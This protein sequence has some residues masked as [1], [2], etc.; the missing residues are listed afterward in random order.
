MGLQ[1]DLNF[2]VGG[3]HSKAS[4]TNKY[5]VFPTPL[6]RLTWWRVVVDEAQ[7]I[8]G[9]SSKAAQ[10]ANHLRIVNRWCVTGTPI[11][12]G[13]SDIYG[14]LLFLQVRSNGLP[15]A[16]SKVQCEGSV[17]CPCVGTTT[18][19]AQHIDML[20]DTQKSELW[21]TC[22]R[23]GWAHAVCCGHRAR[24]LALDRSLAYGKS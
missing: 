12:K 8:E 13:L 22:S 2:D 14:L 9:A 15:P 10:M 3:T 11:S 16:C 6:T 5:P 17:A 1:R 18:N 19:L 23:N 24:A 21:P 20:P 7:M 4:R